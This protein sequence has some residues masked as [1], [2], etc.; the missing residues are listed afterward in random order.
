MSSDKKTLLKIWLKHG[1][2][3]KPSLEEQGP[4]EIKKKGYAKL[5]GQKKGVL[6]K[7]CKWQIHTFLK[8]LLERICIKIK[9]FPLGDHFFLNSH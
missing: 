1:L 8:E 2:K 4:G 5:G 6:R 9:V 3:F 7:M